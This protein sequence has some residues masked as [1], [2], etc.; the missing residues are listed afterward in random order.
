MIGL[1]EVLSRLGEGGM[2]AVY[3]ARHPEMVQRFFNEARSTS[4]IKQQCVAEALARHAELGGRLADAY[5]VEARDGRPRVLDATPGIADETLAACIRQAAASTHIASP[6]PL[7]G[8]Q[9][10]TLFF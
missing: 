6:V 7:D 10:L 5:R 3:L 2:G 4:A 8:V 9:E 1:T